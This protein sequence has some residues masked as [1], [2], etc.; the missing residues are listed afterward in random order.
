LL[1]RAEILSTRFAD[2]VLTPNIAF[3]NLFVARGCSPEKIEIIMNSPLEQVFP[4]T[5][6]VER[7]RFT[8]S[9]DTAFALMFHGTLVER[10]GLRT[11]IEA[12]A[13]LKDRM[14]GIRFDIY[15]E[16][17]HYLRQEIL[18]LVSELRLQECVH[19]QGEQPQPVIAKAVA[20]CDLGIVPNLRTVFTEINLPTR[21]FEYL[22]LGKPVIVPDTKGIRD[23]FDVGSILFFN[24]GDAGSL[25]SRIQ[26]VFDHPQDTATIIQK[27]Q[28]IYRHHL[29]SKE[30]RR[31]LA[32]ISGLI[33]QASRVV[34][35][36]QS[37]SDHRNGN[38]HQD[39]SQAIAHD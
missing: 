20:N 39:H 38:V 29:W 30:E 17:T 14:P 32:L 5:A 12:V 6:P 18:P 21:I 19:Y 27:G 23:Y 10:H 4:M 35:T 2:L 3:R 28:D 13:L 15:G 34:A 31:F 24:A 36:S 1:R 25:A 22:A 33:H 9:K 11:A 8:Q 26:W 37:P 7:P 16:E